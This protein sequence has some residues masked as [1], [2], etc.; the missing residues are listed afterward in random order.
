MTTEKVVPCTGRE[1]NG[2]NVSQV[3]ELSPPPNKRKYIAPGC[4]DP[5]CT[6]HR[7]K[8]EV[9]EDVEHE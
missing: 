8:A 1:W 5:E 6:K 9:P 2:T 3:G 7:P 4:H